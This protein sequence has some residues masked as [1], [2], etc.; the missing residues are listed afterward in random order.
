MWETHIPIC[1]VKEAKKGFECR[2]S[3][4]EV[5][6]LI[7]N[8]RIAGSHFLILPPPRKTICVLWLFLMQWEN[9]CV[10]GKLAQFSTKCWCPTNSL[11]GLF[12]STGLYFRRSCSS[13]NPH[14]VPAGIRRVS[15]EQLPLV[16]PSLWKLQV[17][18]TAWVD[19]SPYD[20]NEMC[21]QSFC[22]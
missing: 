17:P 16:E 10:T 22:I 12:S 15:G 3:V 11:D 19:I 18:M 6:A 4:T 20:L 21:K 2:C 9:A 7:S 13:L 1:G 5:N 14:T 8:F